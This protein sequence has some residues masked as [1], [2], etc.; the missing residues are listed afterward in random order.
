VPGAALTLQLWE[1]A[2]QLANQL[3]YEVDLLDLRAAST[4]MQYQIIIKGIRL[5]KKIYNLNFLK[6]LFLAQKLS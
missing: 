6:C 2:N 5:W 4:V 3:G 1:L